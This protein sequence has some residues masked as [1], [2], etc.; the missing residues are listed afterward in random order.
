MSTTSAP[1]ATEAIIEKIQKLLAM[2]TANGCTESEAS[3]AALLAAKLLTQHKLEMS[4]VLKAAFKSGEVK[5]VCGE[6]SVKDNVSTAWANG[7]AIAVAKLCYC[8]PF[9]VRGG[10]SFVGFPNDVAVASALMDHFMLHA[11]ASMEH[12]RDLDWK[13]FKKMKPGVRYN[14][15]KVRG[16]FMAGY[17]QAVKARLSSSIAERDAQAAAE[18]KQAQSQAAYAAGEAGA[19]TTTQYELVVFSA[20]AIKAWEKEQ[21]ESGQKFA[22]KGGTVRTGKATA[23]GYSAG[24]AAPLGPQ[25]QLG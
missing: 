8:K 25:S 13:K 5:A 20:D 10:F 2:T 21:L 15:G 11:V 16:E 14:G 19:P 4:D 9:G 7:I 24:Q 17:G 1:T 6:G 12:Y 23:A 22:K 18:Q 3:N